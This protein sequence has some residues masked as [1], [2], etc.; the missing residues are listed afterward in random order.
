MNDFKLWVCVVMLCVHRS[1]VV[2][3]VR[4]LLQ[5]LMTHKI[6]AINQTTMVRAGI[7]KRGTA[8]PRFDVD[9]CFSESFLSVVPENAPLTDQAQ[10]FGE[11]VDRCCMELKLCRCFFRSLL[12]TD[13]GEL[14]SWTFSCSCTHMRVDSPTVQTK[15]SNAQQFTTPPRLTPSALAMLSQSTFPTARP[16]RPSL[17]QG[18][19]TSTTIS[20]PI[21]VSRPAFGSL[22]EDHHMSDNVTTTTT[23]T[24]IA[25]ATASCETV[26]NDNYSAT[27]MD[28]GDDHMSSHEFVSHTLSGSPSQQTQLTQLCSTP[29]MSL[30]STQDSSSFTSPLASQ[31]FST[32]TQ[33][34]SQVSDAVACVFPTPSPPP[35]PQPSP[36]PQ[37][38]FKSSH[39]PGHQEYDE[40][41]RIRTALVSRSNDVLEIGW[42]MKTTAI[43]SNTTGELSRVNN[44]VSALRFA[45]VQL[46]NDALD[47]PQSEK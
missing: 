28:A 47:T 13:L 38:H 34:M 3:L 15:T 1:S 44:H 6:N 14:R 17:S 32:Q 30:E 2:F 42:A 23:T 4:T 19:V 37:A 33:I 35:A 27:A 9:Y 24:T 25:T 7:L 10:L 5:F 39:R 40:F 36:R 21:Y 11:F 31:C 26:A 45:L 29:A 16:D 18:S 8:S 12:H 20:D 41:H 43:E 22:F 46:Y